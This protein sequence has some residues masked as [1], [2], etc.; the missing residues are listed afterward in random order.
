MWSLV[1]TCHTERFRDEFL[2]IKRYTNLRLLYFTL[3]MH[4][5]WLI[6]HF[7]VAAY[8]YHTAPL[9]LRTSWRYTNI[10]IVSIVNFTNWIPARS[11]P[12]ARCVRL[13]DSTFCSN[14]TL[15]WS[16]LRSSELSSKLFLRRIICARYDNL[17]TVAMPPKIRGGVSQNGYAPV[18]WGAEFSDNSYAPEFSGAVFL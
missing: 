16:S 17:K 13:P 7:L 5:R 4:S 8:S 3:T 11:R 1:N 14:Q 12:K 10:I 18:I 2:I 6:M 9:R 15:Y